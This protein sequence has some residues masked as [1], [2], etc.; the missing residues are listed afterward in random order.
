MKSIAQAKLEAN[1]KALQEEMDPEC[2]HTVKARQTR[3]PIP[4]LKKTGRSIAAEYPHIAQEFQDSLYGGEQQRANTHIG[5][6]AEP[7]DS[8]IL[9]TTINQ[10]LNGAAHGPDHITTRLIKEVYRLR[11]DL[12][13]RTT[14][15]AWT[16]GISDTGKNSNT[17]LI[18]KAKKATYTV[19]KSWRP[20]QLQSILAKVL[21][22]Q[23]YKGLRT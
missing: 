7:V 4:A 3:H 22:R 15:C 5:A 9:N 19:A 10:S 6:K 17:I 8:G 11:E 14:N 20:V 1:S 16:Q 12:F 2:F 21:E 13:Q 18:P 23:Q